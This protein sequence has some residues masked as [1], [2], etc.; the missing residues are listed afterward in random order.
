M[1]A[2]TYKHIVPDLYAANAFLYLPRF[3]NF[4][5]VLKD[6]MSYIVGE[7]GYIRCNVDVVS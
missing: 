1:R 3:G 4:F 6:K 2:R 7:E 5:Q